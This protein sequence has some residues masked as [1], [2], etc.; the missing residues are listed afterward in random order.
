MFPFERFEND[1][2]TKGLEILGSKLC[3]DSGWSP[4][5]KIS[6]CLIEVEKFEFKKVRFLGTR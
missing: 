1:Q 5:A 3:L 6:G 2:G 4:M